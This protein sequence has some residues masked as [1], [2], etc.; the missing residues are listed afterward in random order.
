MFTELYSFEYVKH[1]LFLFYYSL[2]IVLFSIQTTVNLLLLNLLFL[3]NYILH[4][5]VSMTKGSIT[6]PYHC[7]CICIYYDFHVIISLHF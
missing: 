7:F 3:C 4:I 1:S 2:I 6:V 5:Y